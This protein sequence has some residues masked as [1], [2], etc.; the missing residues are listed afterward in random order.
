MKIR[1]FVSAAWF[2]VFFAFAGA[3]PVV[4]GSAAADWATVGSA[5]VAGSGLLL[6]E[7]RIL[8]TGAAWNL[9]GIPADEPF[10]V[11]F[12]FR[13][14]HFSRPFA[15]DGFSWTLQGAGPGAIGTGHGGLGFQGIPHSL[16]L[17]FDNWRNEAYGERHHE[18]ICLL[19]RGAL[20]NDADLRL[21]A[22]ACAD[23]GRVFRRLRWADGR[24]HHASVSYDGAVLIVMLDG[25]E[26]LRHPIGKLSKW[27]GVPAGSRLFSGFTAATGDT[28]FQRQEILDYRLK[29]NP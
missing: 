13:A 15:A 22:L 5:R 28:Y 16:S 24:E 27:L 20:P 8:E 26:I 21:A 29:T 17:K 9:A 11:D 23:R 3:P 19:S 7:A 12:R 4:T 2:L 10:R 14:G 18:S 1:W 25:R 6:T